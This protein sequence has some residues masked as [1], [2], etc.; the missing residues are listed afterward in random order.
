MMKSSFYIVVLLLLLGIGFEIIQTI[1]LR[2]ANRELS[3]IIDDINIDLKAQNKKFKKMLNTKTI[4]SY[5]NKIMVAPIDIRPDK[6]NSALSNYFNHHGSNVSEYF[7]MLKKNPLFSNEETIPNKD[8]YKVNVL[9]RATC[10][11]R[12]NHNNYCGWSLPIIERTEADSIYFLI[13]LLDHNYS[14]KVSVN[15]SLVPTTSGRYQFPKDDTLKINYQVTVLNYLSDLSI[16]TFTYVDT[17]IMQGDGYIQLKKN[18]RHIQ[19]KY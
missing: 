16:D 2:H 12:Y 8:E 5:S 18:D 3:Q 15:D 10:H 13:D 6:I 11:A 17:F 4:P 19:F 1:Q 9:L 14:Y 7:W